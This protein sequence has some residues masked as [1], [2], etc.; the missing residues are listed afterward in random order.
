MNSRPPP[1]SPRGRHQQL[2]LTGAGT[3]SPSVAVSAL[4]LFAGQRVNRAEEKAGYA[5]VPDFY[6]LDPSAHDPSAPGAG[7]AVGLPDVVDLT[8]RMHADGTL[9]WAPEQGEWTVLRLAFR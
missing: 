5:P 4:Q 3:D 1:A 9:D 2:V 6:A 8:A 7:A